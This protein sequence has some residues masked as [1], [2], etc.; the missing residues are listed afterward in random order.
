MDF[1]SQALTFKNGDINIL[2]FKENSIFSD[3]LRASGDQA[4]PKFVFS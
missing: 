3:F 1:T 4:R 2:I